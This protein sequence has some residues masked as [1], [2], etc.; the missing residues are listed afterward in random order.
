MNSIW[1][2]RKK[3]GKLVSELSP[4]RSEVL[5]EIRLII[6]KLIKGRVSS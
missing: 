1:G 2:I 5:L 6:M 3:Q 4:F